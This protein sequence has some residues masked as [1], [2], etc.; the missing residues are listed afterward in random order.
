MGNA[1]GIEL[2]RQGLRVGSF[3]PG[4]QRL[5]V[6]RADQLDKECEQQYR[7][8]RTGQKKALLS[9][10]TGRPE[11]FYLLGSVA[12]TCHN[13]SVLELHLLNILVCAHDLVA[14]LHHELE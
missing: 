12:E 13:S 4:I 8:A 10:G 11:L 7:G 2:G 1:L 3:Q 9:R 14:N 5:I 6:G